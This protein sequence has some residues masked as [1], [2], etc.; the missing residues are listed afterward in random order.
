M[1][2]H[3]R[4][5]QYMYEK[6]HNACVMW[7]SVAWKQAVTRL[8]SDAKTGL[9]EEEVKKRVEQ[10]GKNVLPEKKPPSRVRIF[11]EQFR[12][13]LIFI[14]AI[15]GVVT[16]IVGEYTDGIVIWAAV[17][18][19]TFVGYFQE[20][21]ATSALSELRK[22]I[23][24]HAKVL[25]NGNEREMSQEELVPGDIIF[26]VSG[27]KVPADARIIESWRLK[28]NEA[29][30][31]GEWISSRKLSDAL[32]KKTPLADRE[33]MVYMGS[34]VSGG[35]G[36]AVVTGI[37]KQTEIGKV[38][39]LV[40]EIKKERTPYQHKL[41]RF[42]WLVA[43][44][45]TAAALFIF[46]DGIFTG[47]SVAEMFAIAVAVAVAAIPEGLPIAMTA[48]L[49]IG[50]Q[51]IL[52]NKGLVRKLASAET[53]GSASVIATDKTLTL[54]EGRMEVQE[55]FTHNAEERDFVF[56]I[57]ASANEAFIENPDAVFE[58]MVF[59]GS[60]TDRALL[61]A[62]IEAG[63]SR[64][65]LEREMPII[66][67]IPFDPTNKYLV[68]FHKKGE[69]VVAYIAGA[70]ESLLARASNP[71]VQVRARI[72]QEL[73]ELT[74]KGLRVV[75]VGYKALDRVQDDLENITFVGLIALR[76]PLRRGV[77]R[78][79]KQAVRAGIRTVIVTG[80]HVRTARAIAQELEI[81]VG[82]ENVIEG[83]ELDE[84]SEEELGKR[85]REITV[86]ARVEPK[87]KM[88]IIDAWQKQDEVIAMTGDGIN[89]APAL[90]KADIGIALG[91]G[92]DVAK[93]VSDLI[94]LDDKFSII[95]AAIKEGRTIIDNIRK[96]ITYLLASA[97]TEVILIGT[98][99]AFGLPLPV[100]AVQILWVNLVEDGLPGIALTF[101]KGEKDLMSR[102]PEKKSRPLLTSEMKSI[103]FIIGIITDLIL[104]GLFLLLLKIPSY[105]IEHIQTFIFVALGIDSLL[106][107]FSCRNLHKNIWQYNPFSN[108]YLVGAVLIGFALLFA[109]VYIPFL[110]NFLN[111]VPLNGVD[112]ALLLCLGL[113]NVAFIESVKWYF[114]RRRR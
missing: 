8:N 48:V 112:L 82:P 6:K 101:E 69:G 16:F 86:Y 1:R 39:E 4:Q 102:K 93:E 109:V 29:V 88:R 41:S 33:N 43:A 103:I 55:I 28:V 14:L 87:H 67:K 47:G 22:V 73:E 60:P 81:K 27:D 62:A 89:D 52:H 107:V 68:S 84:L 91:S 23:K 36:K 40:Q 98:S 111:T 38:A 65:K 106:F 77:K 25:R 94:L 20:Y 114:V 96:V 46:I 78:A 45:V 19:N 80:D 72:K 2:W 59:R 13:P 17:F 83:S 10:F 56:T 18:L 37:G 11:A 85:L 97:F 70:P 108:R 3:I 57:A 75:A 66:E 104:L 61:K 95:P 24:V 50:M 71:S 44:V 100:T 15:A 79:I 76:D 12:S 30:L 64:E 42:S 54:T 74:D 31:T 92:T 9:T 32:K 34:I 7:H 110:Q 26:L 113:L 49:A 58:E 5:E 63:V 35:E 53:L 21:K 51:R 99:V 90:R 105:T